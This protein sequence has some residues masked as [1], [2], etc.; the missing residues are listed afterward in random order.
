MTDEQDR[1]LE[2][3]RA[4]ARDRLRVAQEREARDRMEK[5]QVAVESGRARRWVSASR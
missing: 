3:Q 2:R 4:E 1:V 5:R